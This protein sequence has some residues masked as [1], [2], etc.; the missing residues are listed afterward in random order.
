MAE[1]NTNNNNI[2]EIV[3]SLWNNNNKTKRN[4]YKNKGKQYDPR[5]ND[6]YINNYSGDGFGSVASSRALSLNSMEKD[7]NE[8][9][10]RIE[11]DDQL[12]MENFGLVK[13]RLVEIDGISLKLEKIAPC[14]G[15]VIHGLLP[16]ERA[17]TANMKKFLNQ[18]LLERRVIFF[19]SK[20]QELINKTQHEEISKIFGV[21][22]GIFGETQHT[23]PDAYKNPKMKELVKAGVMNTAK[24]NSHD[25]MPNAASIWHSDVTWTEKPPLGSVLLCK[26]APP[27]GGDTLF[28]DAYA[29]YEFLPLQMKTLL[30]S[31]KAV[32]TGEIIHRL[33]SGN[34]PKVTH[35]AIR[36]H[37]NTGGN[38]LFVNPHFTRS[39]Y[40]N[41]EGDLPE[42]D[43][44]A[45]LNY[46]F[47]LCGKPEF[48]CRFKWETG[49]VAVWDNRACM[50]YASGDYWP[51][52]RIMERITVLDPEDLNRY[53]YLK[54]DNTS[55]KL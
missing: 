19:R 33:P 11:E 15:T 7:R 28:C 24:F 44:H 27:V 29:M 47:S 21:L 46:C 1:N 43:S 23:N 9:V 5:G 55:S 50:H 41:V 49:S 6:E 38:T 42:K 18:L 32:H 22:G 45:L 8:L 4:G 36:T 2:A 54:S 37:P 12:D 52:K 17:I 3:P 25:K 13:Y 14:I 26:H 16:L 31:L 34:I 53:V 51:H 39:L 40:K 35:P 30:K 48:T 20:N 10:K